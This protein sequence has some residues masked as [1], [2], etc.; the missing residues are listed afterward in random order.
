MFGKLRW[1]APAW[2]AVVHMFVAVSEVAS[3]MGHDAP[4]SPPDMLYMSG[5]PP[6]IQVG[7]K[8]HASAG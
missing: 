6:P 2:R 8:S 1:S 5:F 4:N 3:V 7:T